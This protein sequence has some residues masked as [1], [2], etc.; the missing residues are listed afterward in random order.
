M[1]VVPK[2]YTYSCWKTYSMKEFLTRSLSG[3]LYVTLL[4]LCLNYETS[5]IGLFFIFGLIC[6]AEFNKL[7]QLKSIVPYMIFVLMYAIFVYWQL[8]LRS[9]EGLDQATQILMVLTI[10]VEL[11]LIKDLFSEKTIPLFQYSCQ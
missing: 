8:I 1:A 7:I 5:L 9:S 3:I 11:F 6:I 2:T 10:F 4:V